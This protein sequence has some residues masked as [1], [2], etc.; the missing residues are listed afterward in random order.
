MSIVDCF[1]FLLVF[2]AAVVSACAFAVAMLRAFRK[3]SSPIVP[4]Q[5]PAFALLS[6]AFGGIAY[7]FLLEILR[8]PFVQMLL[9]TY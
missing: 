9:A 1:M 8:Q 2:A 5:S 6:I 7:A 4:E 3:T